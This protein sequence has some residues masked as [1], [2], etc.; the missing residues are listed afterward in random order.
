MLYYVKVEEISE[1]IPHHPTIHQSSPSLTSPRHRLLDSQPLGEAWPRMMLMLEVWFIQMQM[2]TGTTK[3]KQQ[4]LQMQTTT[5]T[6]AN[7]IK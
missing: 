2:A 4:K 1:S 7:S 3:F 5:N 6:H